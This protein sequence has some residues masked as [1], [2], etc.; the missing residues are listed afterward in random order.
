MATEVFRRNWQRTVGAIAFSILAVLCLGAV[1]GTAVDQLWPATAIFV[2]VSA[3]NIWMV[4]AMLRQAVIADANGLTL[5]NLFRSHRIP[6]DNIDKILSPAEDIMR[7]VTIVKK[8]GSKVRCGALTLGR[9]EGDHNLDP[10]TRRLSDL[11]AR[12]RS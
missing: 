2:A 9:I 7:A 8:D 1:L 11:L 3:M 6:W 5:R 4:V 10:Q 12:S